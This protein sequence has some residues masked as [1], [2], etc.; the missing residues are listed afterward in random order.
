MLE[1]CLIGWMNFIIRKIII[2][3]INL[4]LYGKFIV[5]FEILLFVIIE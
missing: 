4:L 5:E 2:S 1:L 3:L